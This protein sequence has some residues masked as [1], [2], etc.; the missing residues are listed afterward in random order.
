MM[1]NCNGH[2]IFKDNVTAEDA[3]K[4]A[5]VM[6]QKGYDTRVGEDGG[7]SLSPE[8]QGQRDFVLNFAREC[9]RVRGAT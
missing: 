8:T 3:A 7:G 9:S 1:L 2:N 4:Y 6:V 5:L